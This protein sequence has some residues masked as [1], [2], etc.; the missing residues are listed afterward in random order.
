[1]LDINKENLAYLAALYPESELMREQLTR[2]MRP[3]Q[4]LPNSSFKQT[5]H[6]NDSYI[7]ATL[8][9]GAKSYGY[10]LSTDVISNQKDQVLFLLVLVSVL[11]GDGGW[12]VGEE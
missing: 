3:K 11:K 10:L 6:L 12:E 9:R 1:M 4:F 2:R 7:D 5:G 8:H